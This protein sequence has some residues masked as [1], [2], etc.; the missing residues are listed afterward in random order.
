[1]YSRGTTPGRTGRAHRACSRRRATVIP[2]VAQV[3]AGC[4]DQC[5]PSLS[6]ACRRS[7]APMPARRLSRTTSRSRNS[8][9]LTGKRRSPFHP[10]V[11]W[12][13]ARLTS[14]DVAR[15]PSGGAR[16]CVPRTAGAFPAQSY[17]SIDDV[18]PAR[19][20]LRSFIVTPATSIVEPPLSTSLLYML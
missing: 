19:S 5:R 10:G 8:R 3:R 4:R 13:N 16:R 14:G 9:A 1:M 6:T 12:T 7:S 18:R 2:R 20:L 15:C 17:C 11:R